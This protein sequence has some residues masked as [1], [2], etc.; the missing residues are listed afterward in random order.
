MREVYYENLGVDGRGQKEECVDDLVETY[1]LVVVL[2]DGSARTYTTTVTMLMPTDTPRPTAT[3]TEIPV[4][5]PTWTPLPPTETPTPDINWGVAVSVQGGT[6]Q[7][8]ARGT[9][10]K[11]EL[12]VTNTGEVI[13]NMLVGIVD[14]GP[15]PAE[16]CRGDGVCANNN[17]AIPSMGPG[18]EARITLGVSVPGDAPTEPVNYGIQAVSSGSGGSVSSGTTAITIALQ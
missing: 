7:A 18:N 6:D 2:E 17:L 1:H 14:L 13:D 4:F 16:L 9:T 8:C 15:W 11:I 3:F 10:C 12:V 5:T